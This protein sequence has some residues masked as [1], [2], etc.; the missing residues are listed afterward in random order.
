MS[1]GTSALKLAQDM[2]RMTGDVGHGTQTGAAIQKAFSDH[3][4][5][6]RIIIN[7]D[8]QSFP[9]N[10]RNSYNYYGHSTGL[11][12]RTQVDPK[13]H[14]YAFDLGGY[15]KGDIESGANNRSHQLG[16]MT[17]ATFKWI[18]L[19]ERGYDAQWPWM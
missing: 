10:G 19:V 2:H 6:K 9:A 3:P 7:T 1:S 12:L 4:N 11:S 13:V 15:T 17:D 8:M 5:A 14:M 16:G 18:P